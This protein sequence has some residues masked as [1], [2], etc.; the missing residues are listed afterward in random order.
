MPTAS[1]KIASAKIERIVQT[2][3]EKTTKTINLRVPIGTLELIDTA[4]A[5]VGKSR[6]EFMLECARQHAVDVLLD[7]R[8]FTVTDDQHAALM[9]MLDAPPPPNAALKKLMSG[10]APWAR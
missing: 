6:T 8:L 7:Q 10:K 3:S 5:A 9:R 4:V 2:D 1:A